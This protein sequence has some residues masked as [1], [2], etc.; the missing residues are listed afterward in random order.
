MVKKKRKW[1]SNCENTSIGI[2]ICIHIWRE[3][4]AAAKQTCSVVSNKKNYCSTHEMQMKWI[5]STTASVEFVLLFIIFNFRL[6]SWCTHV[7][8]AFS[9]STVRL[10]LSRAQ[11]AGNVMKDCKT[12]KGP[13]VRESRVS[14]NLQN[15]HFFY[16]LLLL[17]A[18]KLAEHCGVL[19]KRHRDVPWRV[20]VPSDLLILSA[21][22]LSSRSWQCQ[23]KRFYCIFLMW[24]A[25]HSGANG[26]I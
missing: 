24:G 25:Q 21:A 5:D 15:L 13:R 17:A 1:I 3:R 8:I 19:M 20:F 11:E 6:F 4:R 26:S 7:Q 23:F 2:G 18:L 14:E 9:T 10:F 16:D 12:I 22:A